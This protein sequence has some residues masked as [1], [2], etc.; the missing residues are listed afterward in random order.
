MK[1][2]FSEEKNSLIM[3]INGEIDHRYAIL[4]RN[5]ADKKIIDSTMP[6][7]IIDLS[8]VTF[9]DSSAI[10]VIIGRYKL[11]QSLGRNISII[12]SNRTVGKI[13]DMSGIKKIIPLWSSIEQAERSTDNKCI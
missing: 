11:I 1:L 3:K 10:G 6:N 7:F 9:M 13:L 12:S 2:E 8:D 5:E 4:I